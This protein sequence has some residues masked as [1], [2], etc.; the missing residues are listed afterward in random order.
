M[1]TAFP[2]G[3]AVRCS[4]PIASACAR[5][6]IASRRS[7]ASSVRA[8][9]PRHFSRGSH[10]K[11]APSASSTPSVR[12]TSPFRRQRRIS[13]PRPCLGFDMLG[14]A[15]STPSW[16]AIPMARRTCARRT[17]SARTQISSP[18]SSSTGPRT[19][20]TERSSRI[21]Q[22]LID[23]ELSEERP[24]VILSGNGIEHGLLALAAMYAGVPYAPI[25]PAYSLIA[26]EFGTLR[27]LMDSLK[28]GLV[29][30]SDGNAFASALR[31]VVHDAEVVVDVIPSER[32]ESRDL[33]LTPGGSVSAD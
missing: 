9:S 8:G 17:H 2:V 5:S 25:A 32:S 29:Y 30:A 16:T 4:T 31:A 28:P 20:P 14:S 12:R 27:Y 26:R 23:R 6:T 24:L 33:H 1:A 21:A 3:A 18:R 11:A 7:I 10:A 13:W 22:A 15:H 19:H